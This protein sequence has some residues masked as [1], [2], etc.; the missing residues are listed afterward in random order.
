MVN[1]NSPLDGLTVLVVEDDLLLAMDL[2][3][4]L[5]EAGAI[6]VDVCRTLD[7]A[8]MRGEADD[9]AV[10]VL[11]FSLGPDPVTPFARRLARRGIPFILH[12]GMLCGEPSLLEWKDY[13]VLEKPASSH[14]LVSAL[15]SMTAR[16]PGQRKSRR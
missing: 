11:D 16:D 13:P 12:T 7:D 1:D 3:A 5:V 2:E 6:V 4:A 8:M 10:A 14:R 9:F 15:K